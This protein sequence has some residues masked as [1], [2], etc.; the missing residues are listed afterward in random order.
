MSSN[1]NP[2]L[3]DDLP[4]TGSRHTSNFNIYIYIYIYIYIWEIV[5]K[6][7]KYR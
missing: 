2:Q 5:H 1:D 6:P 7:Y 3:S 4:R